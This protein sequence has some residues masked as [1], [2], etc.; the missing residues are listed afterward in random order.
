[1]SHG[2]PQSE[3][4]EMQRTFVERCAKG[5]FVEVMEE[6]YAE[7][8]YQIEKGDGTRREGR[9]NMVAF[10]KD[11]L[12][13]VDT[14]HGVDIGPIAVS[15]DDGNGNGVTMAQYTIKA[16]MKDG[17]KFS[18]EQVQVSEWKNGK[19]VALRYYYNPNF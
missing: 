3:L 11:F 10:E 18:P 12:T 16:D 17:S 19:I 9:S 4:L 13:K 2:I 5:E 8:A 14:F 6:Y 7:D 15:S 1:M